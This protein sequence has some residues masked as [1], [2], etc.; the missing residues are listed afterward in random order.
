MHWKSPSSP[1]QKK[2]RMSMSKF[3]A[4]IIV[5]SDIRGI[6]PIEWVPEGRTVNQV[7]YM[8]ILTT[9]RGRVGRR[10][11][12]EMW[13]N[14]SWILHQ[15]D[16]P[17]LAHKAMSAKKKSG[18]GTSTVF[19]WSSH[20][21]LFLFLKIKCGLQGTRFESVDAVKKRATQLMCDLSAKLLPTVDISY[22]AVLWRV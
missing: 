20:V 16:A 2:A 13:K 18:I 3:K 14:S 8:E 7:Y 4:M 6:V 5:F 15:D 22:E 17:A 21:W 1:R 9:L 12:S 10:R 19:T 11:R